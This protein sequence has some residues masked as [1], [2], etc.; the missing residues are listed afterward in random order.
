MS[1]LRRVGLGGVGEGVGGALLVGAVSGVVGCVG[2]GVVVE[3]VGEG[4]GAAL[5]VGAKL[6]VVGC[7]GE[8]GVV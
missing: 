6:M 3:R 8:G 4:V 7:V 1:G 5:F 2:E